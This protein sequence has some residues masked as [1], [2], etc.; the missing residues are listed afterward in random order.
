MNKVE[1]VKAALKGQPVD[2]PPFSLWLHFPIDDEDAD[3]FFERNVAFSEEHDVDYI[4]NMPSGSF[5]VEDWGTVCDHSKLPE[6]GLDVYSHYPI[7]APE[8]WN[9]IQELNI[10]EGVLGLQLRQ[11]EM[12]LKHVD[13]EVPVVQIVYLP[14]T[15]AKKLSGELY[16]DHLK[17]H[18]DLVRGALERITNTMTRFIER[19]LELGATG[20]YFSTQE[21][22]HDFV[23]EAFYR[24]YS[25]PYNERLVAAAGSGW[26]NVLHMHGVNVMF[27]HMSQFDVHALH[28]HIGE[29][30]PS[31]AEYR[32]SG[33]K[34]A[35][36]GGLR[37]AEISDGNFDATL[38]DI[39]QAIEESDGGRGL[40][41]GPSCVIDYPI[42]PGSLARVST[43]L[44]KIR[45]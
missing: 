1:R 34:K 44:R 3:R 5:S 22:T 15:V 19:S 20:I 30:A 9:R 31:I 24:T 37:R 12:L 11:L 38:Q 2:R 33:G 8:D 28:W 25:S 7:S 42:A 43:E 21:A 23:T 35:V 26:F 32:A 29:T 4:V 17:T 13:G 18:E 41:F 6:G 40:L 14:L 10:D 36:L 39:N 45:S 27:D 16:R